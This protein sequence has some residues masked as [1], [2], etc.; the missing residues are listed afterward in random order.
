MAPLFLIRRLRICA[1]LPLF[2]FEASTEKKVPHIFILHVLIQSSTSDFV[3]FPRM[4]FQKAK[5][6]FMSLNPSPLILIIKVR[7]VELNRSEKK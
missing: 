6:S 2:C 1:R 3:G 4:R 7:I 5:S